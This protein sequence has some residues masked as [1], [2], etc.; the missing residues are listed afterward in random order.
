MMTVVE[1]PF[2]LCVID[3]SHFNSRTVVKSTIPVS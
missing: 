3:M 1:P 2:G